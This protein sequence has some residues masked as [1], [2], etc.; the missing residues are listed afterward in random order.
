M[1]THETAPNLIVE[2]NGFCYAYRR[3]GAKGSTPVLFLQHFRGTMDNWDPIVINAIAEQ[4]EVILFDNAG[5]GRSSGLAESTIA[6]STRHVVAFIR[7]LG[8]GR[9]DVFGFSMG[10]FIA[11]QLAHDHPSLVSRLILVGTGPEGGE[12]I[13]WRFTEDVASHVGIDAPGPDDLKYVFFAHSETSQKAAVEFVKR[14]GT[15]TAEPDGV[16]TLQVRDAQTAA[17]AAWGVPNGGDYSKLHTIA[18]PA[19]V[20]N[21]IYD[22]V[23]PAVNSWILVSHLPNALL[24][25][26]PDA[27]HGSLYQYAESFNRQALRFLES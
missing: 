19:L 26:Y 9:V 12:R 13:D 2:A 6:A 21:G 20:V 11:Q 1:I 25:I 17:I 18:Q 23:V 15:R 8:L 3:F 14:L 22:I 10:G 27:G 24:L 4:R 16:S 7:A 5:V